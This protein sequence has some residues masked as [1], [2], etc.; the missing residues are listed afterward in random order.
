MKGIIITNAFDK[1]HTQSKKVQRM[2][3]EFDALGVQMQIVPNDNFVAYVHKDKYV[4]QLLEKCK[5]RLFNSASAIA[6][7][8][9][10]MLTHIELCN[11]GIAM[12]TTMGG[13]LC[14]TPN[15]QISESYLQKV[16]DVLSL[17]LI[18]KQ[19]YGSYGEQ[20]YL[21]N[22]MAEL[23]ALVEKLKHVPYLF[24]RFV[25]KSSGKDMRVIVIGGKCVC[26]M[27]RQ[28]QT[29]FRS[30]VELGGVATKVEKIPPQIE[31]LCQKTAQ[32]LGLDYCGIDVLLGDEPM[33]CE[34]NSNA[35]F[36][37]MEAVTGVNVAKLFAEHIVKEVGK[38]K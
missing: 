27:L 21:V 3:Q 24:Q 28:S 31:Q 22:T 1:S 26:A 18:V 16:V 14:Y 17:P 30:N 5:L 19:C 34:V 11:N 33:V 38:N 15:G 32:V 23:A 20:V 13:A 2:L 8:D 4:A 36:N 10:K 7:C 6:K 37:A 9:D 25:Q 35:M 12:P 29:D